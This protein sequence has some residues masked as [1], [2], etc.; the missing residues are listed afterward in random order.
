MAVEV[1]LLRSLV[2]VAEE[3]HIG[4]AAERL[5]LSQPALS[6][7]IAQLET[8][9][10]L[11]L[12]DRHARGVT[13]TAAG[14]LLVDRAR[15]VVR[16]ADSFDALALR[17]RRALSGRLNVGFVGQ[18]ANEQTP[19]LLRVFREQNP[20]VAV[21]LRQYD[22][23][24]LTAGLRSGDT[25]LG[26]LRLP[27]AAEGLVHEPLFVEPR[28]AV[29]PADHHLAR[30]AAVDLRRLL[31]EPW[32]VSASPDPSYQRFALA[33]DARGGRDPVRG[34]VVATIDEYLEAVLSGRGIGLAPASAARYYSRP[35]ITYVPVPDAEPSVCSLSRPTGRRP[36][37]AA[38]AFIG[39]VHARLPLG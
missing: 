18:A 23:H 39:I 7:Q 6:K 11:R 20:E 13:P 30:R 1:R 35:G 32:V 4:R 17:T 28:V 16:E 33:M 14:R 3:G 27:V 21:E 8:S 5:H 38:H 34:P 10:G 22:M 29:L 12:F 36:N 19:V 2:V 9:T 24:D 15:H 25:D 37:P 31:D 26:I